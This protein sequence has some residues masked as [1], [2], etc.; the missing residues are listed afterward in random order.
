M[1]TL[2]IVGIRVHLLCI[3]NFIVQARYSAVRVIPL[4]STMTIAALHNRPSTQMC[5][6]HEIVHSEFHMFSAFA[7]IANNYLGE[8][9]CGV[10]HLM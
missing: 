7:W 3:C 9:C 8:C 10:H 6:P 4:S 5:Y 1:S 2:N